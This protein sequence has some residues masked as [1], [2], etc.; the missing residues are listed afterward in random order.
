MGKRK[1]FVGSSSEGLRAA[2]AVGEVIEDAGMEPI[3][4]KTIFP[5]GNILL[6][7]IEQLPS[8]VDGAVLVAT[9]DLVCDRAEKKERFS[10]PVPN[11]VFE[12][13]YLSARLSRKR[14][15]ICSFGDAEMPSD[16]QGLIFI[17]GG[18][19]EYG[20]EK[21]LKLPGE[22]RTGLQRWLKG[23]VPLAAGIAPIYQVHGYSGKWR[24]Q[25][26]F[27]LWHTIP[28]N[29]K[30]TENMVT[31]DGQA[32]IHI[33]QNGEGG[34]GTQIGE[35]KVT[36]GPY[37]A[38]W[39]I[40][41]EITSATVD[42]KGTLTMKVEVK[43]RVLVKEA[44]TPPSASVY[45]RVHEELPV[46]DWDLVLNTVPGRPKYLTGPHTYTVARA[47]YSEAVEDYTY[48]GV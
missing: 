6:D 7:A 21:P 45:A 20:K 10:A 11:V 48:I 33:Q 32:F 34:Y 42:A 31:F 29:P 5:A 39:Q 19:Y 27:S 23:L 35:L 30:D 4:W 8:S 41:N 26:R 38:T 40:A 14:V 12:Y 47:P 25:N 17:P 36:L 18:S 46:D 15:A 1:I 24:V 9:P 28:L 16:F 37:S 44:G 43:V 22:A 2:E 13:G 3:L